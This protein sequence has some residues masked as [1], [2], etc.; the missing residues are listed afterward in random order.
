[1]AHAI[2]VV[3]LAIRILCERPENKLAIV[4]KSGKHRAGVLA[5]CILCAFGCSPKDAIK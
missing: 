4:T 3:K 5:A 1:M 2:Q